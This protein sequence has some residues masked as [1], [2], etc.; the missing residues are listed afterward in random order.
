[1]SRRLVDAHLHVWERA[2]HPQPWIDPLT[3]SAIDRDYPPRSAA[4]T[5]AA[6]GI[7]GAVVIQCV[8]ELTETVDILAAASVLPPVRGV[9]GWV[10]LTSDVDA[11]LETLRGGPGGDRLVGVRHVTF[12][13]TDERWLARGDVG[14][15]LTALGEGDLTY[16]LLVGPH[17]LRL[18]T[19]VARRHESTTF[20]LDHLGKVPITSTALVTWARDLAELATCANVAMKVSGVITEDDWTQ[21]SVDRLRPVIDHALATFGPS[22]LMFGSD[23]PVVELA[24]GYGP[25][26]AAYLQLTDDLEPL[27]QAAIDGATAL[28]VYGLT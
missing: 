20:V 17:Q 1:M 2:R 8:N 10:D 9:V 25:W 14:R 15:G 19:E 26:L 4:E 7:D 27:E 18:A 6:H 28:R 3:M 5:L 13:E 23:W 22:R 11:Q 24:G 16:D 21:W 12:T